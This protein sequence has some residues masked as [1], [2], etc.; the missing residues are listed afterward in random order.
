MLIKD[1]N[2]SLYSRVLDETILCEL[3]HP[4]NDEFKINFS[5]AHAILEPG[6][7]YF[8]TSLQNPLKYTI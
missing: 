8:P 1:V 4:K 7:S 5:V 3:L 6:K 2:K